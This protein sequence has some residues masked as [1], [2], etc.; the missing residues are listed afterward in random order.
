[1]A[2]PEYELIPSVS[3]RIDIEDVSGRDIC[4]AEMADGSVC[5]R[6]P[7]DCPYHGGD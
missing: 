2:D 6:D 4:G 7:D 1:M 3:E 5:E